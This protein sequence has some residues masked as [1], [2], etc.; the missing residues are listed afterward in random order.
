MFY[1]AATDDCNTASE[2][3]SDQSSE[4]SQQKAAS[5]GLE[6]PAL[7][8]EPASASVPL[9][10][11]Q[12]ARV[13]AIDILP[14][15]TSDH[16]ELRKRR[17]QRAEV[18]TSSPYKKTLTERAKKEQSKSASKKKQNC[19]VEKWKRKV[20]KFDSTDNTPC[21]VCGEK[22]SDDCR[23]CDGRKWIKCCKCTLRFHT[24]CQ[25]LAR[26]PTR[27]FTCISCEN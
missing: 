2:E 18:L 3:V 10:S 4:L 15:P 21:G 11:P 17:A 7:S 25:G 20:E 23:K 14:Y 8:P 27:L 1:T 5:Y 12:G 9:H 19:G 24:E 22:Y 13:R 16:V 6:E 26:V